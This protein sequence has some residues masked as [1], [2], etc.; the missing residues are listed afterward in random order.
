MN[1]KIHNI[2]WKSVPSSTYLSAIIF[3]ENLIKSFYVIS[4]LE[5]GETEKNIRQTVSHMLFQYFL[6]E[7]KTD[8]FR[9]LQVI[10]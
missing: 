3:H 2:T 7:I 8:A 6:R 10:D 1:N 9:S 5:S 4:G